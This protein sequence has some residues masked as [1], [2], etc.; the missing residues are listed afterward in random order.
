M[1]FAKSLKTIGTRCSEYFFDTVHI[2][3]GNDID[4]L[5]LLCEAYIK[6]KNLL[7][8]KKAE[9]FMRLAILKRELK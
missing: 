3:A 7:L 9:G 6:S 1:L 5:M 2:D 8:I 4:D